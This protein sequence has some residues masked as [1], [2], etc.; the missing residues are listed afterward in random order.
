[1]KTVIFAVSMV[2]AALVAATSMSGGEENMGYRDLTPEEE[3]VIVHGG[4]ERPFTG[5]FVDTF[6]NGVY[7]C[8][9]C[10]APLF[11][12]ETK[13]RAHCG[14]P[15]FDRAIENAVEELPDA[16][17][18]RTEI[19]CAA[20]GAHLGHVF[21]G[22]G[23]TETDTRHCVNSISMDFIP[24]DS[25][26]TAYFAGGCFWGIE[27]AFDKTDGV[28]DA[29]SGYMGGTSESP[30]YGDVCT[31]ATGH[32]ETVRVIFRKDRVS[33]EDLAKM[34][35]EI[36]DPT[37]VNRQGVD[38]GTQ[39]RSAVYYTNEAQKET[40]EELIAILENRGLQV[41]TEVKPAETFYPAEEYHQNYFDVNGVRGSCHLRV[42]RF[43]S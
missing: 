9:R 36:H 18:L 33:Y 7:T 8:R 34:F 27:H 5:R 29:A 30:S 25:I 39:Y 26:E 3:S 21:T 17:G 16:D 38:T 31:G 1:M 19:R 40:L 32:A 37:Q 23:Y 15:A 41:A 22:E 4:T 35:F 43:D 13:F 10:G 14:W 20:C 28:I 11:T 12:S 2:T 6:D 24:A 42:N